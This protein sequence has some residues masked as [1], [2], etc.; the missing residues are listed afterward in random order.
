MTRLLFGQDQAVAAWAKDK[1]AAGLAP[2]ISALGIV[3]RDN[4]IVGAA[5]LHDYNGSNVELCYWGPRSL[6]RYVAGGIA[7]FCF[8]VL[9]VNRVTCRTPRSNKIVARHLTKLGFRYEGLLRSYYGPSRAQDAIMFGLLATDATRLLGG[10]NEP[11][12]A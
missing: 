7:L 9:R 2:W 12:S 11:K 8:R 1:Y 6:S 3:D 4:R 5:T 10:L